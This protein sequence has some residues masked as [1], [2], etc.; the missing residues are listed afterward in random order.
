MDRPFPEVPGVA[1]EHRFVQARGV[2]FHVAVAGPPDGEPLLIVHGWPQNW[3]TWRKVLPQLSERYRCYVPDLRGMGWSEPTPLGYDKENF[4]SD[5]LALMDALGL[6]R[7]K[8]L[9][10]DWGGWAGYLMALREPGRI[11]RYVVLNIPPPWARDPS[12]LHTVLSAW[13]LLYQLVLATKLGSGLVAN[14]RRVGAGIRRARVHRV[15]ISDADLAQFTGPLAEPGRRH[16]TRE[17]Y[18]TFQREELPQLLRG[19]YADEPL[20]VPTLLIYGERDTVVTGRIIDH[21]VRP[22][23]P[24][25][26]VRVPDA[27]HFVADERPDIVAERA[28][29]F[30][31]AGA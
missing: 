18:R 4:A 29:D 15:A 8:L 13:R 22:G 9:A 26:I 16:V 24:M 11:E 6:Q 1:V 23:D 30:F 21:A 17:I 20:T 27:G 5:M 31:A 19:R 10:H 2:R 25:E 7:V 14:E 12:L 28:L 3:F